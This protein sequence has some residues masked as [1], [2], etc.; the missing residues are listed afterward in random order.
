MAASNCMQLTE[1]WAHHL[2]PKIDCHV[3]ARKGHNVHLVDQHEGQVYG[4]HL[5]Q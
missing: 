5:K 4:W 3:E 1:D 2:Q